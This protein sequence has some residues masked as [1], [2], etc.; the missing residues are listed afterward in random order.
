MFAPTTDTQQQRGACVC[1]PLP[2]DPVPDVGRL[3][4]CRV[5][6]RQTTMYLNADAELIH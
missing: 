6:D 4:Y 5:G 1:Q 3:Q 2:C